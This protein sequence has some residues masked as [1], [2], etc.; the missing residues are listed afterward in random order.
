MLAERPG[1]PVEL[2]VDLPGRLPEHVEVGAFY[3]VAEALA[4]A[5]K[6]AGA[7]RV[8]VEAMVVDDALHLRVSDDGR[9]G[10]AAA[11]GSGIEGLDDRLSSLGGRLLIGSPVG[12]GTTITAEI[13]LGS[14]PVPDAGV[15]VSPE[16]VGEH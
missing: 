11:P 16:L 1:V 2:S 8:T 13:P 14:P 4:N 6:Y 7:A 12:G 9:G 15:N 5:N 3:V 10:A